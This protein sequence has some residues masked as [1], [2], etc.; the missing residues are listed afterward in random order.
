MCAKYKKKKKTARA[1]YSTSRRRRRQ[2]K[3]PAHH[4]PNR[5]TNDQTSPRKCI[6][7]YNNVYSNL[8]S[9]FSGSQKP[10]ITGAFMP[11]LL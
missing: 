5:P 11:S 7:Y 8:I 3:P 9:E 10:F 1:D 4:L 2:P 6:N